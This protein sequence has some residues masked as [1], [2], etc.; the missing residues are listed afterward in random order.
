M[1]LAKGIEWTTHICTILAVLPEGKGLSVDALAEFFELPS[2]Y[3]SKQMQL[4]RRAG[5]AASVRG[6]SGGYRLARPVDTITLLDIVQAIEG[7]GPAFRCT[8]IRQNG[9]CALKRSD[10]KRPCEIASAFAAA[11]DVYHQ[12]LAAKSL[13]NIMQEAAANSTPEH[14]I[15]IANWVQAQI[16]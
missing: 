14:M 12:A 11:E 9:P 7:R 16:A 10:C 4:L 8:E 5:I 1:Q 3:L 2:G 15:E 13:A 6:K